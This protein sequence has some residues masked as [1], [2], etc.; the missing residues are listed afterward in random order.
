[1]GESNDLSIA[2]VLNDLKSIAAR[3]CKDKDFMEKIAGELT[4]MGYKGCDNEDA[5]Q[6][7]RVL[8]RAV[9]SLFIK[10]VDIQNID[11]K[12]LNKFLASPK[13]VI[14]NHLM[15]VRSRPELKSPLDLANKEVAGIK[16]S[17]RQWFVTNLIERQFQ[18]KWATENGGPD[19]FNFYEFC[20]LAHG[21]TAN[22][23]YK[24]R[25]A[26]VKVQLYRY[27]SQN[28]TENYS[29]EQLCPPVYMQTAQGWKT[30]DPVTRKFD[31]F[32]N[33]FKWIQE[34]ILDFITATAVEKNGDA[35]ALEEPTLYWAVVQDKDV[36]SGDHL[37]IKDIGKTQVYVGKA[38]NG[39]KG[40]WLNDGE[41]HCKMMKTCLN[42]VQNMRTYEPE[43]L[44]GI[45]LV[46]ARLLLAKLREEKCALF[47]MKTYCGKEA[48]KNLKADEKNHI[49][50]IKFKKKVRKYN[51]VPSE[52][53]PGWK[54][55]SMAYGM[56]GRD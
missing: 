16:K 44:E 41:S 34:P 12:Q 30:W 51:I 3:L 13:R 33:G 40:R 17:A 42:N 9:K 14:F 49:N 11:E 29:Q 15:P 4:G 36:K 5:N 52:I 28:R 22:L 25:N 27:C 35:K 21:K 39:V 38:N 37:K 47:V 50:G 24:P 7:S 6:V 48:E 45:Q 54:P 31:A 55:K 20:N 46:D 53:C 18:I 1:M 32:S 19:E 2:D 56:N 43:R 8:E 26:H 10:C 23:K